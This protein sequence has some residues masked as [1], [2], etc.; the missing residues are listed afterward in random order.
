[1]LIAP[2]YLRKW[3][4][5]R[6][7]GVL[8]VGAHEAE[9]FEAYR[10][11]NFGPTIWVEAQA[12]L[13]PRIREVI[14]GTDDVLL[15]A[16][17][18][19]ESGK[20]FNFQVTSETQSSSL[21]GLAEHLVEYPQIKTTEER[22]VTT[23]RLD[24]VISQEA[25]FDFVT[26]DIQGA[27]LEA[28]KGMGNLISKVRWIFTEVNRREMYAGIPLVEELDDFLSKQG[29]ERVVTLWN[30]AGW[31]DA[32]YAKSPKSHLEKIRFAVASKWAV[33][34]FLTTEFVLRSRKKGRKLRRR[35]YR[36]VDRLRG[37][38]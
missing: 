35:L 9:E 11:A 28:L 19:S 18:W 22:K 16:V 14:E 4:G 15:E 2:L 5:A 32:L 1:M 3:F 26:L 34:N 24:E 30:P 8:H 20:E 37:L 33:A 27:E 21:Y 17:A 38:G 25:R 12:E 23:T 29:F 36:F 10:R 7:T 6:P 31:G 13:L